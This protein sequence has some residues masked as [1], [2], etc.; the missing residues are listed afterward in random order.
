MYR[1]RTRQIKSGNYFCETIKLM[2]TI[3]TNTHTHSN[4]LEKQLSWDS[5]VAREVKGKTVC[6]SEKLVFFSIVFISNPLHLHVVWTFLG[7][8]SCPHFSELCK[9]QVHDQQETSLLCHV[10]ST[11]KKAKKK[12]G[13]SVPLRCWL[14]KKKKS[15]ATLMGLAQTSVGLMSYCHTE[16]WGEGWDRCLLGNLGWPS[17]RSS[18]L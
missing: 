15:S 14:K 3:K 16:M 5:A 17:E 7:N 11:R 13:L 6:E 1:A 4:N 10:V 2:A 18:I 8:G 12:A 9:S